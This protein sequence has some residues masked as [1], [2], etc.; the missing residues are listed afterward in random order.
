[1]LGHRKDAVV[2]VVV[3]AVVVFNFV[4]FAGEI[5]GTGQRLLGRRGEDAGG[6]GGAGDGSDSAAGAGEIANCSRLDCGAP[7]CEPRCR[8]SPS[9]SP[10]WGCTG[11]VRFG[12]PS[13]VDSF[14][15]LWGGERTSRG[16]CG[17]STVPCVFRSCLTRRAV[18][19]A[20]I[21][22]TVTVVALTIVFACVRTAQRTRQVSD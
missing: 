1:M 11:V 19:A 21:T 12:T 7:G 15:L 6:A 8:S 9:S 18:V 3:A 22:V 20:V 4:F 10:P 16:G 13:D 17:L 5:G 14:K 2:M